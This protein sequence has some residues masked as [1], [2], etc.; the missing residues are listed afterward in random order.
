MNFFP[1]QAPI[2]GKFSGPDARKKIP[3]IPLYAKYFSIFIFK[4]IALCALY[5]EERNILPYYP[6]TGNS[7]ANRQ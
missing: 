6:I 1:D 5:L 7:V 4:K 2:S 3:V